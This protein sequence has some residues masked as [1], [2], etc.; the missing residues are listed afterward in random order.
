MMATDRDEFVRSNS[1]AWREGLR[2]MDKLVGVAEPGTI[3][4][5]PV[6]VA[7]RTVI[8]ASEVMVGLGFGH[9]VGSGPAS[10]EESAAEGAA[11]GGGGGGGGGGRWDGPSPPS[12][13]TSAACASSR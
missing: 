8:T 4:S 3:F 10:G 1:Q 11:G 9:G 7:G 12:S 5:D 13:S 2:L 6:T